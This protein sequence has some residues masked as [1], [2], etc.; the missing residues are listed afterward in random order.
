MQIPILESTQVAILESTH[1]AIL[2]KLLQILSKN[3]M[4]SRTHMSTYG[5]LEEDPL[6]SSVFMLPK[7]TSMS[8]KKSS[9]GK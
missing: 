9:S 8:G 6:A 2:H 5:V 7:M 4:S 3:M 1:I